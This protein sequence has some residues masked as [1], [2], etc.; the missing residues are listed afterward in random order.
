MTD[1]LDQSLMFILLFFVVLTLVLILMVRLESNLTRSK[2]TLSPMTRL[3][4]YVKRRY[5]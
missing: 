5:Q 1:D 3:I 4:R 2:T